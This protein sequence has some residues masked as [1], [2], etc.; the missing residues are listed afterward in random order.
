MP[1]NVLVTGPYGR[2]GTGLRRHLDDREEYAFTYLDVEDHPDHETVVA[3]VR[4]FEAI[5]PAFDGQDAVVHLALTGAMSSDHTEAAWSTVLTDEL[6]AI[7]NVYAAAVEADVEKLVFASTNQVVYRHA[8]DHPDPTDSSFVLDHT[9]PVRPDS[10]YSLAK[11]YGE[12]FGRFC[13]EAH[14]LRVYCL[15]IGWVQT[16]GADHPYAA[17]EA[18]V[19]ADGVERGSEAYESMAASPIWLSGR[20]A[21]GLVDC[22]LRDEDLTFEVLYGASDNGGCWLDIDRARE[23]VGYDPVDAVEDWDGPP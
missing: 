23:L 4:E 20:D 21:A 22:C 14:G 13:T 1:T 3:D 12:A 7:T 15:R 16:G 18:A 8:R 2:V 11:C 17:A 5:R 6:R 19:E 10:Q 9:V